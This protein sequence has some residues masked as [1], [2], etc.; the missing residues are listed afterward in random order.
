MIFS[1]LSDYFETLG[2]M[3]CVP[4]LYV[5]KGAAVSHNFLHL[6]VQEYMAALYLSLQPVEKQLKH[7]RDYK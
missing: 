4:E 5:D 3:H 7:F 2:L 6:I 1:D